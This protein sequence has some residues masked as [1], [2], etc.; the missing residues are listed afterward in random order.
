MRQ[1]LEDLRKAMLALAMV[2]DSAVSSAAQ[3]AIAR[4]E[5]D[6]AVAREALEKTRRELKDL[7]RSS[8]EHATRVLGPSEAKQAKMRASVKN[9]VARMRGETARASMYIA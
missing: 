2:E 8:A 6:A 1:E 7:H 9:L 3:E 4:A 5:Q